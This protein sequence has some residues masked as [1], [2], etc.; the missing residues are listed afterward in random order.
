MLRFG[1]LR[2][3]ERH[4]AHTAVL[5]TEPNYLP[6][7]APDPAHVGR[8]VELVVLRRLGR[9]MSAN[10]RG[11]TTASAAPESIMIWMQSWPSPRPSTDWAPPSTL[12]VRLRRSDACIAVANARAGDIGP[13]PPDLNTQ[14]EQPNRP[15]PN[16]ANMCFSRRNELGTLTA[17]ARRPAELPVGLRHPPT[18]GATKRGRHRPPA[19]P[20]YRPSQRPRKT[21][22][23]RPPPYAPHS[24]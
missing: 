19:W 6:S 5:L 12:E 23:P 10:K 13:R 21:G 15:C 1:D 2:H 8:P 14:W 11:R 4:L 16:L 18:E 20:R 24:T 3:S 22:P 7:P 17:G 9:R